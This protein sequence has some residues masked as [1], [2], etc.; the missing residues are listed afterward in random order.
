MAKLRTDPDTYD[1]MKANQPAK[2]ALIVSENAR[3]MVKIRRIII[4][5]PLSSG[6]KSSQSHSSH[7]VLLPQQPRFSGHQRAEFVLRKREIIGTS[8]HSKMLWLLSFLVASK[9][10]CGVD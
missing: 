2:G 8:D 3:V 10:T 7:L 5:H 6:R 9:M 1:A 4:N